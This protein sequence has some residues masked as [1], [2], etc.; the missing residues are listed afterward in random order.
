MNIPHVYRKALD[1]FIIPPRSFFQ[2]FVSASKGAISLFEEGNR[3][4]FMNTL[5]TGTINENVIQQA[6]AGPM[7]MLSL[8]HDLQNPLL[9]K[10]EF[11]PKQFLHGVGPALENFHDIAGALENSLH[12]ISIEDD[13]DD[14]DNEGDDINKDKKNDSDDS[15]KINGMTKKENEAILSTINMLQKQMSLE[16]KRASSILKKDWMEDAKKD[17]D[18]LAGRMSRMLTKEL[19]DINQLSA[20]TAF[21]LQNNNRKLRF[22][23]G[24]CTVNNVALLSARAFL[25]VEQDQDD[26]EDGTDALSSPKYEIVQYDEEEGEKRK[27]SAGVAAQMEILYDVTQHFTSEK[28]SLSDGESEE[29]SSS[30]RSNGKEEEDSETTIVSVATL[31]GWLHGGP[32]GELR[33][34]LALHRPAFE[35][36]GIEQAY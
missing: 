36:P 22:Q 25:C 19:F 10:H 30:S 6:T 35:F 23:E 20:K 7:M 27:P 11:D 24:S 2:M 33:W 12:S 29:V 28:Q 4:N 16:D 1:G 21:L 3:A 9:R 32:E 5:D 26:N 8:F 13:N 17:D 34:R 18:G 15:V 14:N 31:E